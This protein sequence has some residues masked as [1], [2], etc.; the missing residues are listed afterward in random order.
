MSQ[1]S[2]RYQAIDQRGAVTRGMLEAT[3]R[4][5]AYRKMVASGLRPLRIVQR[6]RSGGRGRKIT[7][8][9]LSQFTR[10]FAVLMDARIP[11]VDGLR[12]IAEQEEKER[13]R[14]VI[15]DVASQIESGSTVTDALGP[16]RELFGEIYIE[17]IRAAEIS[18]N[19][20]EV[21][22]QLAQMLD[23]QY[24]MIKSVKGAL[25]YPICVISAL[26]LAVAFLM[27]FVVP[28]FSEM[29]AARGV[30]LP[31]PTQVVIG[32]S[33]LIRAYWWLLL[34]LVIG[35]V[36]LLRRAWTKP[37]SR[38]RIDTGLHHIPFMSSVMRGVAI[39]RFAGVLGISLRSG[40]SLI[41][42]L[43]MSGRASGRPL[44]QVEA[45]KLRDQVNQGGR[46]SDC[47]SG[48][49]YLPA[50]TRRMISAGEEA[51]ELPRMCEVIA[52]NYDRE[53]E[54]LTKNV[55][56]VI[57][58]IMIVGLASIVLVIALSVFLP[59]WNMAAL[60]N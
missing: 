38:R 45:E 58:P 25:M 22:E 39:S 33:D 40:L 57:E 20:I 12:S 53:V 5:E 31:L 42:A 8:R 41:D 6:R 1:L 29:F 32:I 24:E 37:R 26:G 48:C 18:G 3:C 23:R 49:V 28:K 54:H 46:L 56:T 4:D 30:P 59:M 16:H 2:F 36:F 35:G 44:L 9:D 19:M 17:T 21:L 27:V 14:E 10:Q 43:E 47:I 50:F 52:L 13:L 51:G 15:E 7:L 60:I 11:I 34:A 55:A